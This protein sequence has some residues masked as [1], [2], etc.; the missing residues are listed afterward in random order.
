MGDGGRDRRAS[1]DRHPVRPYRAG[2]RNK[3]RLLDAVG[4]RFGSDVEVESIAISM[5]PRPRV[6]GR[7]LVLRHK[8]RTDVPPLITI[9]SFSAEASLLGFR[10]PCCA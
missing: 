5:L 10:S 2:A 6:R 7:G 1:A 3:K 8:H 4:E 9:S